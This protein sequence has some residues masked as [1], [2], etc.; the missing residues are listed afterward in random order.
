MAKESVLSALD[1]EKS[2]DSTVEILTDARHGWRKNARQTDVVCIGNR[3]KKVLH[4]EMVTK[5]NDPAAQRHEKLGTEA[6]YNYLQRE[7]VA[8]SMHCHDNNA[9]ITKYVRETHTST[10]NQLDN[11]HACKSFERHVSVVTQGPRYKH[12]VTW[13]QQLNDKL[14]ALKIHLQHCLVNCSSDPDILRN[15]L[16]NAVEHYKGVHTACPSISRCR[17]EQLY[18]PSK[19]LI[20]DEKAESL[21]REVIKKVT[22]T[23]MHRCTAATL[24]LP[25]WNLSTIP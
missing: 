17:R 21:L 9:S 14:S 15:R 24:V 6:I 7:G 5:D 13:H 19:M 8:V 11:W 1:E 18:H 10:I 12:G 25:T 16:M 20:Q 23:K 2:N 3:T 4:V 22:S